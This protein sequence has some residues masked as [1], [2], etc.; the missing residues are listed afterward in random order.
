MVRSSCQRHTCGTDECAPPPKP[1]CEGSLP[2]EPALNRCPP[3]QRGQTSRLAA[4]RRA[5]LTAGCCLHDKLKLLGDAKNR[6][7][8]RK[9]GPGSS[10][11]EFTG[12]NIKAVR[13]APGSKPSVTRLMCDPHAGGTTARSFWVCVLLEDCWDRTRPHWDPE[14]STWVE[15]TLKHT[16][17]LMGHTVY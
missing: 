9:S 11:A 14:V 12:E 10:K 16:L 1:A 4:H 2:P 7:A 6:S 17:V 3:Q 13:K 8:V 5:D 15:D